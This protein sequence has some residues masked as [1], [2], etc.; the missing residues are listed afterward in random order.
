MT[1]AESKLKLDHNPY[2]STSAGSDQRALV[3]A[4]T[5][6]EVGWGEGLLVS[7]EWGCEQDGP[8]DNK[9]V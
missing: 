3:D 8:L 7:V 4:I 5:R 2:Y 9:E 1:A 6:F